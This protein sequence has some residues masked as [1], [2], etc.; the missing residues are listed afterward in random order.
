MTDDTDPGAASTAPDRGTDY[1]R[2]LVGELSRVDRAVYG[3]IADTPTPLLDEPMRRLSNAANFSK[4]WIG[5]AAGTALVGGRRGRRPAVTGLVAIG[6]TSAVVNQ[7]VK[8]MAHR[9]RPD[10]TGEDV[11]EERYV[12]MPESTSFPSGHSASA[13]AFANSVGALVPALSIPLHF[14]AGAVAYSRVHTGVHYPGDVII[15]SLIGSVIGDLVVSG[16]AWW[17]RRRKGSQV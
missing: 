2:S 16:E 9:A 3:A 4:L 1:A 11:P 13:F 14:L 8:R 6:V 5:I 7:G 10:R 15:G 12:H 17:M